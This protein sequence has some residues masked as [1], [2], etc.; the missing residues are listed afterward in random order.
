MQ[1]EKQP[2]CCGRDCAACTRRIEERLG[3]YVQ[4]PSK[5]CDECAATVYVDANGECPSCGANS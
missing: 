4:P 1:T 5:W 3:E 2:I